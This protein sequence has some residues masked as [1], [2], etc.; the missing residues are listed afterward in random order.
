MLPEPKRLDWSIESNSE[1]IDPT[2]KVRE[3][4]VRKIDSARAEHDLGSDDCERLFS[5]LELPSECWEKHFEAELSR[6]VEF[7][8][9]P[10]AGRPSKEMLQRLRERRKAKQ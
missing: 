5:I 9:L 7:R 10:P 4:F 6:L 3:A 2:A 8:K 1:L